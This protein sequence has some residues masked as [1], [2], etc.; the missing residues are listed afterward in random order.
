MKPRI[1]PDLQ[2]RGINIF[3]GDIT[4]IS[5][6]VIV[7]AA[8]KSLLG[9]NGIDGAIHKAAGP[10]LLT[11]CAKLHGCQTG[12]SKITRGYNLPSSYVIHTVGPIWNGGNQGEDS[13]LKSCYETCLDIAEINCFESIVFCCISTGIY[14]FPKNRAAKIALNTISDRI[15]SGLRCE[16]YI[17]CFSQD[18]L[19]PYVDAASAI[20]EAA[21][22]PVEG[23]LNPRK[24]Y[25]TNKLKG[26]FNGEILCK[27]VDRVIENQ[28]RFYALLRSTGEPGIEELISSIHKSSFF[29][30]HS[31]SHH[32]YASGTVEHS[33]GVYD[34]LVKLAKG[35]SYENKD[36]IITAL[37]HDICMG[38]NPIWPHEK[39]RHGKNSYLITK[40]YLHN[41]NPA[42]LE[43]I[44]GHKHWPSD[45]GAAHN[46][47]RLLI[48]KADMADAA[49]SP[50]K[51]LK[52]M[53]I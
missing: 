41:V 1:I 45:E 6:D 16:V 7:N 28:D 17:C 43:A 8:N 5:A 3:V 31:Y 40:Q 14:G 32:H 42:V 37:L 21:K 51:T 50:E 29:T 53:K 9:G 35:Y 49:T 10:Q 19:K 46:P 2:Y 30:A 34:Q 4:K 25:F 26:H 23:G 22:K 44:K 52:F 27:A 15:D 33:L 36:L 18:D 12:Q 47:L 48:K 11:E 38:H 13:L 20:P 24:I 39:G